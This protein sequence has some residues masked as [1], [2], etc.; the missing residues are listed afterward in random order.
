[1]A[2]TAAEAATP[3]WLVLLLAAHSTALM[4]LQRTSSAELA[5]TLSARERQCRAE[6]LASAA[7]SDQESAAL[8][9]E[10]AAVASQL[11]QLQSAEPEPE[12]DPESPADDGTQAGHQHSSRYLNVAV[13]GDWS[14]GKSSATT[15]LLLSTGD[16]A[17]RDFNR[18]RG[19]WEG[20][21]GVGATMPLGAVVDRTSRERTDGMT[22][23]GNIEGL[24][25]PNGRMCTLLDTPGS[26]EF[27]KKAVQMLAQADAALLVVDATLFADSLGG[28]PVPTA[29][30]QQW[31]HRVASL[32]AA[33][34]TFSVKQI[35]LCVTKMDLV[36]HRHQQEVFE[37]A[38]KQ[39]L[40]ETTFERSFSTILS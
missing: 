6:A 25:L 18:L 36:D 4:Q 11:A 31:K 32:A 9:A 34:H 27:M 8:D 16:V 26:P 38:C 17:P 39:V 1:M 5:R 10:C 3:D 12:P 19:Y 33:F 29:T 35:V 37:H 28:P 14:S 15:A 22:I 30:R 21:R 2:G 13:V 20:G 40:H 24:H 7:R 23:N